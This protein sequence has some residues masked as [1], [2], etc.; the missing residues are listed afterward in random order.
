[1][2]SLASRSDRQAIALQWDL[3]YPT[4]VLAIQPGDLVTGSA[5]AGADKVLTC[6]VPPRLKLCRCILVGGQKAISD[7]PVAIINFQVSGQARVGAVTVQIRNAIALTPRPQ[8]IDIPRT[9]LPSVEGR[10]AVEAR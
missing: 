6:A 8:R 9:D 5:A 4:D 10:I 2:L 7:G 3:L 1:M